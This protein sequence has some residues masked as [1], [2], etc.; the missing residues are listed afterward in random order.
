MP[1]PWMQELIWVRR[2]EQGV[3]IGTAEKLP[4]NVAFIPTVPHT[5]KEPSAKGSIDKK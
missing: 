3:I 2:N 4:P 5:K 1:K